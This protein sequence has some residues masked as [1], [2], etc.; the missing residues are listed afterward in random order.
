M[1]ILYLCL[2]LQHFPNRSTFFIQSQVAEDRTSDKAPRMWRDLSVSSPGFR[3]SSLTP[4]PQV[5]SIYILQI[6]HDIATMCTNM[7]THTVTKKW[8]CLLHSLPSVE[9][10]M[11]TDDVSGVGVALYYKRT[12]HLFVWAVVTFCCFLAAVIAVTT[13]AMF[14]QLPRFQRCALHCLKAAGLRSMY[15]A[16]P[17]V[18]A[19][20]P[21]RNSVSLAWN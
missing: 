17:P 3:P 13:R 2:H 19:S 10:S 1:C 18:I 7:P 14:S 6:L 20:H 9:V 12:Q 15:V 4:W 16:W 5:Y 8:C 21:P 11:M